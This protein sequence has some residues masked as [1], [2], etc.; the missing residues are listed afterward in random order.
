MMYPAFLTVGDRKYVLEQTPPVALGTT[1]RQPH[2]VEL[3]RADA[4]PVSP[5]RN[6]R[7]NAGGTVRQ[8]VIDR[9]LTF[10][11]VFQL[12]PTHV[13]P[14]SSA[15]VDL[16]CEMNKPLPRDKAMLIF[17]DHWAF[18]NQRETPG[19]DKPRLCGGAVVR[20][21]VDGAN[22]RIETLLTSQPVPSAEYVLQRPWLWYYGTQV[23]PGG[24]VSYMTLGA[25]GGVRVPVKIP[26][27]TR[28]PVYAPVA[29]FHRLP[30]GFVPPDSFWM[31][32]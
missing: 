30:L 32:E 29:W 22:L 25:G 18:N 24:N 7:G 11:E 1:Y 5:G 26:L 2:D 13:T 28:F 6:Y 15:W 17:D 16:V 21:T 19:F 9:N 8:S 10:P 14:L 27:V 31:P 23:A 3:I 4:A 20:G 12:L